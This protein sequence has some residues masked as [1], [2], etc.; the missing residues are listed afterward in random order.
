M[1]KTLRIRTDLKAGAFGPPSPDTYPGQYGW[2]W[3]SGG[4]IARPGRPMKQFTG[5][6]F[7]GAPQFYYPAGGAGAGPLGA[8]QGGGGGGGE[9][10]VAP[11][12]P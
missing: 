8:P 11:P 7:G 10:Q 9:G 4:Y 12:A 6:W 3:M 5:W 1:Q 2:W